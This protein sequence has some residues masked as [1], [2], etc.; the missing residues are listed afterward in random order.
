M[1]LT[2]LFVPKRKEI[3]SIFC[4]GFNACRVNYPTNRTAYAFAMLTAGTRQLAS[5]QRCLLQLNH[6]I[7]RQKDW[8]ACRWIIGLPTKLAEESCLPASLGRNLEVGRVLDC[9]VLGIKIVGFRTKWTAKL[10]LRNKVAFLVENR[11][12]GLTALL[13]S[14]RFELIP[15][16]VG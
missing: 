1:I 5:D 4:L 15:M 12:V 3:I 6:E 9:S 16:M 8:K 10:H 13:R 7:C 14:N 11:W 2:I